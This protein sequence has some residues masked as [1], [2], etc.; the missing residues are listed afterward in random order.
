M[1]EG[2]KA[3]STKVGEVGRKHGPPS[4][5]EKEINRK[6]GGGPT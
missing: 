4:A 3:G 2:R 5:K 1:K 6:R